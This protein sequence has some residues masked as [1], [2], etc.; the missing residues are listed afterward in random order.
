MD[1]DITTVLQSPR[2]PVDSMPKHKITSGFRSVHPPGVLS[3]YSRI[4]QPRHLRLHCLGLFMDS[5]TNNFRRRSRD[6]SK[7]ANERKAHRDQGK[8]TH[9]SRYQTTLTPKRQDPPGQ[10]Q[11]VHIWND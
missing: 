1:K 6:P 4:I 7:T 8:A 3:L 10:L 2:N 5:T 9:P 11:P